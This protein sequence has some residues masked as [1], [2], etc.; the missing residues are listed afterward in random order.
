MP[1]L[2][3]LEDVANAVVFLASAEAGFINGTTLRVDGGASIFMPSAQLDTRVRP[4]RHQQ[5]PSLTALPAATPRASSV[6]LPSGGRV[7]IV[8]I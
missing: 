3:T 6:P 1:R 2:C 5:A 4:P 7:S 8:L